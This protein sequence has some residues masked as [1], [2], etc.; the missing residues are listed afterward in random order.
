MLEYRLFS[1]D[2]N[3]QDCAGSGGRIQSSQPYRDGTD[4]ELW[5][6]AR[7]VAKIPRLPQV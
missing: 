1:L 3:G 2:A 6:R 4:T 5:Q 7:R